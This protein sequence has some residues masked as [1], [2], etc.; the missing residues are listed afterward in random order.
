[1]AEEAL[2][3]VLQYRSHLENYLKENP[4][5]L[6][7]LAP[8]SF[9]PLAPAIIKEMLKAAETAGVG[10]M[11]AVAGA[12]AEFVGK[13]LLSAGAKEVVVENG[14][15]I[16]LC[17]TKD[18]R[19]G[20]FAGAS[21]LSKRVGIKISRDHMPLGVC[22]SSGTV[23][24]SLSLGHAD[25][26]TVLAES[27]CLADALATRIANETKNSDDITQALELAKN[28]PALMG[29]VIIKDEKIGAWGDVELVTLT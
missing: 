29:L 25:S 16:Y 1:M 2:H 22:T 27:A 3:F 4:L 14:G 11:A 18:C 20:I 10:P 12:I 21:P 23:G 5:F 19:V 17:R 24:H 13:E 28:F 8:L 26:V 6:T 7:A 15:D 9:D